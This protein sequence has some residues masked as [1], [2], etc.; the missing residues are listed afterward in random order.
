MTNY[1][2]DD[3]RDRDLVGLTI[4]NTDNVQYKLGGIS[5]RRHFQLKPDVVSDVLGKVV[6]SNTRYGLNNQHEVHFDHVRMPAV[7]GKRAEKAIGR[8][9]E[10]LSAIKFYC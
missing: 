6:P 9:L 1:V 4:R 5:L 10:F 8:S 3:V 2:F 7:Y